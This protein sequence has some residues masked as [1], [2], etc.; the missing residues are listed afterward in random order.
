MKIGLHEIIA[1]LL[2]GMGLSLIFLTD[3]KTLAIGA[4]AMMIS[5]GVVIS[6]GKSR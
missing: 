1:L 2:F 4:F 3:N 5:G 6:I